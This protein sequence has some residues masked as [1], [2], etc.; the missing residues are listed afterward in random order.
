MIVKDVLGKGAKDRQHATQ[1][2]TATQA[3]VKNLTR[4]VEGVAYMLG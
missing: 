3:A 4:S 2:M 1:T